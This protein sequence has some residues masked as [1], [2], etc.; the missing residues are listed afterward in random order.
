[1]KNRKLRTSA[2]R[3]LLT[4]VHDILTMYQRLQPEPDPSVARVVLAIERELQNHKKENR[5]EEG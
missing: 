3:D 2:M 5:D 4:I 1:M